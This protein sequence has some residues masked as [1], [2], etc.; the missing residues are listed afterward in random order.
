MLVP[1]SMEMKS[2]TETNCKAGDVQSFTNAH[3]SFG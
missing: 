1:N 3:T 2:F